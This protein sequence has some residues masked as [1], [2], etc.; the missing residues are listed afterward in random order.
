MRKTLLVAVL[1]LGLLQACPAWA[2]TEEEQTHKLE[3]IDVSASGEQEP[4]SSPFRLPESAK[5]ATWAIDQA[6]IQALNPHDVFDVLAYAPGVQSSFQGRKS[7]NFVSSRGGGN[8]IGGSSFAFL[9]DGVYMPWTQACRVLANFPVESIASIKVVRDTT[10]MTLAPLTGLGSIGTAVQGVIIIKTHKPA[11][12]ESEVKLGYGNLNRYKAYLN[13][14]DKFD[15]GYYSLSYNKSHDDGRD[16]W[17]NASDTDSLLLK[18]GY[19]NNVSLKADASFYYDWATREIQRSL[20]V[21]KTWASK[22]E[23]NPLD[24]LMATANVS[25][26]WTPAQTTA[27]GL[28]TGRVKGTTQYRSY[29]NP[30]SYSEHEWEDNVVQADLSHVIVSGKNN[31]RVGTQAIFWDSPYG[32]LY[33]EGV[34]REEELYSAYLHD[35]YALTDAL[36]IDGGA[37]IDNRHISKGINMYAP[38]DTKPSQLI[39]DEWADPYY[40]VAA[41]LA[42]QFNKMLQGTF[43][44]SYNEQGA[45]SFLLTADGKNLNPEKQWRYEA[46]LIAKIHPAIQATATLFYYDIKDTKQAVGSITDGDDII[47]IYANADTVRSGGELEVNGYVFIPNI[48]Y[49]LNYTY[50]RSDN[51]IDDKSVPHHLA[52]LRLGYRMNPFQCN[53]MMRYVSDYDS[54]EFAVNNLYY[55]IG[56]FSRIDANV[57]YDFTLDKAQMRATVFAQNL[58]NEEYQTRLGWEDVGLTYGVSLSAKF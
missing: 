8:F 45:D 56:D 42:Y 47:N 17:N 19:D 41:G 29:A 24:T 54:N 10:T 37:R 15:K 49:G 21:S 46:G 53:L 51:D 3:T 27:L 38:T 34:E 20:P 18:G 39:D 57:S 30:K 16:D 36:T 7:M 13:H 25:K 43:R 31:F 6:G 12:E 2:Q 9:L 11:K 48:T 50:Q 40:A 32:Q 28:Y 4:P 5:A 58:T 44:L 33:Y 22:W 23:Y 26:Q 55:E 1:T 52:S 14:G 35:E